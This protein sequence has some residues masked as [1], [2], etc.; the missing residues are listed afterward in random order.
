[1]DGKRG[2]FEAVRKG[3]DRGLR[4]LLNGDPSLARAREKGVSLLMAAAPGDR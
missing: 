1:M 2:A 3:D 4:V